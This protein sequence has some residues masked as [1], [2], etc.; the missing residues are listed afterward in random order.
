MFRSMTYFGM[1]TSALTGSTR[2]SLLRAARDLF[3]SKGF[4]ATSTEEIVTRAGVTK[5]ALYHHFADKDALFRGVFEQVQREVS[6]V[7]VAEFLQPDP[8]QAL[9]QGCRHS[10][11]AHGDPVVRQI[12]LIDARVVL[13]W[14]TARAIE[15][16]FSTVAMRGVLRKGMRTGILASRP[17]RP[18]SLMLAGAL[19]EACLYVAQA[20]NQA[21]ARE[22]VGALITAILSGLRSNA[23]ESPPE[24]VSG[25]PHS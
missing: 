6:D 1:T 13:G 20:E 24:R 12:V 16:R 14:E 25:R 17:L 3:G 11:D 2:D 5:G 21:A 19:T 7:A 9:V 10:V 18:L 8:W 4:A 22:E 15:T 23:P